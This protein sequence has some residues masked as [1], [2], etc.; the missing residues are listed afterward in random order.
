MYEPDVPTIQNEPREPDPRVLAMQ[1]LVDLE[2]EAEM[3]Q[4]EA[5]RRAKMAA[6]ASEDL[7]QARDEL[8]NML[9][10]QSNSGI[11]APVGLR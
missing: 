8:E 6:I 11:N 3:A 4:R 2:Q 9:G 5:D 7:R 10:Y 1:K